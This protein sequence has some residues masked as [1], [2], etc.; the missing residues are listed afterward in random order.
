[1]SQVRVSWIEFRLPDPSPFGRGVPSGC[2]AS[3][4]PE[5]PDLGVPA[6]VSWGGD[7]FQTP[8]LYRW[9]VGGERTNGAV[10]AGGGA[11]FASPVLTHATGLLER[12]RRATR[13]DI[14]GLSW[15]PWSINPGRG[16]LVLELPLPEEGPS[17]PA[18]ALAYNSQS[19][20]NAEYDTEFGRGWTLSPKHQLTSLTSTAVDVA[21]GDGRVVRYD[22]RD[23]FEIYRGPGGTSDALRFN[24]SDQSWTQTAADGSVIH[25]GSDGLADYL[26]SPV[27]NRWTLTYGGSLLR[28]VT[29]PFGA[30]I[31]LAYD[32]GRLRRIEQPSGRVT[33]VSIDGSGDLTGLIRPDAS[34]VTL[35]YAAHRLVDL[36]DPRGK[37]T[38]FAYSADDDGGHLTRVTTPTGDRTTLTYFTADPPDYRTRVAD[39]AGGVTTLQFT[40]AGNLGTLVN[41]LNQRT[42]YL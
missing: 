30:R 25:F 39:P 42:T 12:F 7:S 8:L 40:P 31:S 38:S 15:G 36:V 18:V 13:A 35:T 41:P 19:V 22:D 11:D 37:S 27:G 5:F 21:Y 14:P 23:E 24:P 34:R 2:V 17:V 4:F 1:M 28:T 29:D 26:A 3:T 32:S 6:G 20:E 9:S 10:P 33:T 16:N